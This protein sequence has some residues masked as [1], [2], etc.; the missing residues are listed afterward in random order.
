M[1]FVA[2]MVDILLWL[3]KSATVIGETPFVLRYDFKEGQS[4]MK[5]FK[6]VVNTLKLIVTRLRG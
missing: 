1:E 6:T 5:I 3:R 2:R 4:K